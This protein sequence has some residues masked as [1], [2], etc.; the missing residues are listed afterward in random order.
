MVNLKKL[1]LYICV[2]RS[3]VLDGNDLKNDIIN[4]LPQLNQF[5][6]NIRSLFRASNQN[7]IPANKDIQRTL[8][9]L[10]K[11]HANFYID[12]LPDD[13]IGQCHYYSYPYTLNYYDDITNKFPGGLFACVRRVSLFDYRPFEHQ[14]FIRLAQSFP[15]MEKLTVS[16]LKAQQQKLTNNNQCISVIEYPHLTELDFNCAH[17]DYIEQFLMDTKTFLW[18]HV[19]FWSDYDPL[20]RATHN[21][22]SVTTRL[23]STKIQSLHFHDSYQ[24]SKSLTD[25][26]PYALIGKLK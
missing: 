11:A 17:S 5:M 25:Y 8:A 13:R 21:F 15:L 22:T 14:F 19:N 20:K 23:N 3:T 18:N 4:H 26:F 16:N 24:I 1:A 2:N 12:Y 7:E 6:Y 9:D 10:S